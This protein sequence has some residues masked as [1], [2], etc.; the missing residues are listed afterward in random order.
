MA[1]PP[2]IDLCVFELAFYLV[3]RMTLRGREI[4]GFGV[5]RRPPWIW[6]TVFGGREGSIR[7]DR[8]VGAATSLAG[9]T[10]CLVVS[11]AGASTSSGPYA[12]AIAIAFVG[13]VVTLLALFVVAAGRGELF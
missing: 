8:L 6:L 11:L 3:C 12:G 9:A 13:W 1:A 2:I 7:L 4:Q 5:W 10:V